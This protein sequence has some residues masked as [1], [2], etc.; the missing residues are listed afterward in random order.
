[1]RHLID[2]KGEPT[3]IWYRLHYTDIT[4]VEVLRSTESSVWVRVAQ[5]KV[6][7]RTR[8]GG[9]WER[10]YAT[11]DE[12]RSAGIDMML[13]GIANHEKTIAS[14]QRSLEGCKLHIAMLTALKPEQVVK[15][16]LTPI[17]A[18]TPDML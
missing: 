12:A 6:A 14:A 1:M 4:K 10:Y 15:E 11:F 8:L 2:Y 18:I 5:N 17:P 13:R 9:N 7:R 16:K 3:E